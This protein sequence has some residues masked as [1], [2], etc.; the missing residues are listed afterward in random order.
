MGWANTGGN[1][2]IMHQEVPI[3]IAKIYHSL[4][5]EPG[6]SETIKR[7]VR[8][9][10]FVIGHDPNRQYGK[11]SFALK[12]PASIKEQTSVSGTNG[13]RFGIAQNMPSVAA[14]YAAASSELAMYWNDTEI[15]QIGYGPVTNNTGYSERRNI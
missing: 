9:D 12:N 5:V 3:E 10:M 1:S 13:F 6:M 2:P 7:M 8:E 4:L 14:N 11:F 15:T